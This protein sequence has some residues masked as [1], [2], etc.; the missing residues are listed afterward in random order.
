MKGGNDMKKYRK[1]SM[2]IKAE[3]W[4]KV[5]YDRGAKHGFKPEDMPIYHLGVGHFRRPGIDGQRVCKHCG[6]IMHNHGWVDTLENGYIV[7]PSDWIITGAKV[8]TYP[9]K[10]GI[11]EAAYEEVNDS[12]ER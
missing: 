1:K 6:D 3:Q 7:C 12:I 11:F 10:P 9:C 5:T 4:F 2:V 8:E